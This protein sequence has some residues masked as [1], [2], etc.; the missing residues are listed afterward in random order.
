M[1][2]CIHI[3]T[4]RTNTRFRSYSLNSQSRLNDN[5][6]LKTFTHSLNC[7]LLQTKLHKIQSKQ[8]ERKVEYE[9]CTKAFFCASQILC[10]FPLMALADIHSSRSLVG[11]IMSRFNE[12]SSFGSH[13]SLGDKPSGWPPNLLR[14]GLHT[15]VEKQK[16]WKI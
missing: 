12:H 11:K 15:K 16:N 2:I 1:Y 13:L 8:N 10:I 3:P 4:F 5:T 9:Y 7:R 14:L 6:N